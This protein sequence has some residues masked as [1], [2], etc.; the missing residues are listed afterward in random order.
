MAANLTTAGEAF[1]FNDATQALAVGTVAAASA[2][3]DPAGLFAAVSGITT[4]A[5]DINLQSAGLALNQPVS[6]GTGTVRLV[7][8]GA[9]SQTAPGTIG[10]AALSVT[11]SS[12]NVVLE[13]GNAVT[14]TV[15]ANLTTA[16]EAF[17]FND[18]TQALAVGTVAAASATVD[19][20]GL[21][22]AVSGITTNAADINLQSAGLALNQPVSAGTGTVRLV[23]SGA[24][25][26]TAPGTIGAAALSVTDS[27]GNVVLELG[28]AVTTTVA[29]NLTT[30]GEAFS[31]NDRTIFFASWVSCSAMTS[32]LPRAT[33]Q[34]SPASRTW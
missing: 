4:N 5:A 8:S 21:F 28:N 17:S 24:V 20:A 14:T 12:G 32:A 23:E 33:R 16:G 31:F 26:Q 10:A 3:V 15:A 9:V 27:S 7:E 22:A 1:S 11:D 29:A 19:P 18:A 30:A 34:R 2:T 6:A 25:S 13:L